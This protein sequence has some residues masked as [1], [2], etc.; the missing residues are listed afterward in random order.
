MSEFHLSQEIKRTNPVNLPQNPVTTLLIEKTYLYL[1]DSTVKALKSIFSAFLALLVLVSAT[2]FTID[3]HVCM[4]RTQ[5]I[6]ILH[7]A[8]PCAMELFATSGENLSKMEG[9]CRDEQSKIEGNE[10]QVKNLKP[11]T[12]EYQSLWVAELPRVITVITFEK[13]S[14]HLALRKH[15]PPLPERD[16]PVLVQSFLI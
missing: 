4:G 15:K 8:T 1:T 9:C 6:A 7:E 5:S 11:L 2:S 10:Y 13:S 16:I 3:R 12:T 14:Q